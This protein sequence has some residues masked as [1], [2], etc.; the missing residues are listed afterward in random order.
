V[1]DLGIVADFMTSA[2]ITIGPDSS[3]AEA[4]RRVAQ[5]HI[6]RLIVMSA[7]NKL[8]GVVTSLD[9]LRAFPSATGS[10]CCAANDAH[11]LHTAR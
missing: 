4:A 2:P 8:M 10:R 11:S 7:D 6:H 5:H 3:V 9:L 1:V